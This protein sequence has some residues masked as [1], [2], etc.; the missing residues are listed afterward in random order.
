[1]SFLKNSNKEKILLGEIGKIKEQAKQINS[2]VNEV[3]A[4]AE[5]VSRGAAE[6]I[7]AL[8]NTLS[9]MNEMTSSLKGDSNTGR[10]H[11]RFHRGSCIWNQ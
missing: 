11:Q 1:M 3:N 10:L 2:S 4:I 5:E 9:S 7:G 8:D 6:Q